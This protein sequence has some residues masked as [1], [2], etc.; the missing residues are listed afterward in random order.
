[1]FLEPKL[2]SGPIIF[3]LEKNSALLLWNTVR[4]FSVILNVTSLAA[5]YFSGLWNPAVLQAVL[6][7]LGNFLHEVAKM[8]S[9]LRHTLMGKCVYFLAH[10]S[11]QCGELAVRYSAAVRHDGGIH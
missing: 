5:N 8:C 10:V 1:M 2:L 6:I 11:V 9:F 7:K 3:F 4:N